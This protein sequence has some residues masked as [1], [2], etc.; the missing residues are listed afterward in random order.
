MIAWRLPRTFLPADAS[1][2]VRRAGRL[3][4]VLCVLVACSAPPDDGPGDDA[5][6]DATTASFRGVR[7]G[8]PDVTLPDFDVAGYDFD[9]SATPMAEAPSRLSLRGTLRVTFVT[10]APLRTARFDY[11]PE[12]D[13][14]SVS[15]VKWGSRNVPFRVE[16]GSLTVELGRE[17]A[18][19][20]A[21]HLTFT[22]AASPRPVGNRG[23]VYD[24]S[25]AVF[26]AHWPN[27]ARQWFPSRDNPRDAAMFA[28]RLRTPQGFV[29]LS[30]GP[31][32]TRELGREVETE[33]EQLAP[34]APYAFFLGVSPGWQRAEVPA[35][36]GRV[37]ES[38][39]HPH[40]ASSAARAFADM[41]KALDYFERTFGPYRWKN[42]RF[43]DVQ[44]TWGGGGMEHVGAIAIDPATLSDAAEARTT[45]VHELAHHWSGDLVRIA[46]WND[47][48]LSE[49]FTEY[50]TRRFVEDADGVQAAEALWA[51]SVAGG[52]RAT[53]ALV[54]Q[55]ELEGDPT[56]RTIMGAIFDNVAY[57]KGAWVM[58]VLERKVGRARF[59]EFLRGWFQ[60]HAYSVVRTEDFERELSEASGQDLRP[61]FQDCVYGTRN[62]E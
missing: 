38:F 10:T 9:L 19:G 55:G 39:V 17:V 13:A 46:R 25:T 21:V 45:S 14:S 41:P 36:R 2:V 52:R 53:H 48:W 54:P 57:D 20:R 27:R 34:I 15:A 32:R 61:F 12:G 23:L 22:L 58:R 18:Q 7:L 62:P 5:E 43:I 4:W 42:V 37:V 50:L 1:G 56:P 24:A 60:R 31:R 26:T 30:N 35:S 11:V 3:P 44:T 28:L 16:Q 6:S 29:A 51:E 47:F 40:H 33:S 59:T 49:G 8:A